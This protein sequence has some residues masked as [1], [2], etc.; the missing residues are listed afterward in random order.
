MALRLKPLDRLDGEHAHGTVWTAVE[1]LRVVP[2]AV[3]PESVDARTRD[4]ELRHAAARHVDLKDA[5]SS[6]HVRRHDASASCI[7]YRPHDSSSA[8][9]TGS[10]PGTTE[11]SRVGWTN[12]SFR[13]PPTIDR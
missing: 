9:C 4:R 10:G 7:T 3:E 13:C 8:L 2:V 5:P 1:R 11:I 6:N 12:R